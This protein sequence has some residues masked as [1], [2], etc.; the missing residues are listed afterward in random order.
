M[1]D[2]GTGAL[3]RHLAVLPA[4]VLRVLDPAPGETFVDCTVGAGGHTRLLA[5]RVGP[6][7]RVVGL[8]CD[9]AM[10]ELARP[11][12]DGLPVTLVQASFDNLRVV[13]DELAIARVDGVLAD[14]GVCS[15]QLDDPAR[16]LS[17]SQEG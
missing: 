16:G 6:S 13:L 7:G 15:A 1:S 8:D 2:P 5:E 14:L 12:L 9:Q 3:A 4:E 17:F 11:R 10:L